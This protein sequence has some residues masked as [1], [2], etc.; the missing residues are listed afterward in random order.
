MICFYVS[1]CSGLSLQRAT[2]V[3]LLCDVSEIIY[4][5]Q[6]NLSPVSAYMRITKFI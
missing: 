3:Y 6:T 5:S 1:T 2:T 4:V